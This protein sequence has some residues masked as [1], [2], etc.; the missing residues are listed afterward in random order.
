MITFMLLSWYQLYP[1]KFPAKD[2]EDINNLT[3]LG[4]WYLSAQVAYVQ[5]RSF[6]L[7]LNWWS[8]VPTAMQGAFP[9]ASNFGTC[10]V[11]TE[12]MHSITHAS[13]DIVQYGDTENT[14]VEG[15][16]KLLQEWGKSYP[17]RCEDTEEPKEIKV[18]R[19]KG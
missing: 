12:K 19:H 8:Q 4:R 13:N 2:Q 10:I 7:V 5:F 18:H 1:P 14:D 17:V 9:H 6:V 15:P 11:E 3:T 16:E